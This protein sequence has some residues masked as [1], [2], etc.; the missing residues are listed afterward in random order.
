MVKNPP[1]SAGDTGDVGLIPGSG[2]SPGRG[3]GNPF[4]YLSL[5]N[6]RH[7]G[8]WQAIVHGVTKSQPCR[9]C[10]HSN[11]VIS[12][13]IKVI[14]EKR[15]NAEISETTFANLQIRKDLYLDRCPV[16]SRITFP[17]RLHIRLGVHCQPGQ[18][19][20]S[21]FPLF[22]RWFAQR[23][24]ILINAKGYDKKQLEGKSHT[25]KV[26]EMLISISFL[27]L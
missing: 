26:T 1:A 3:N 13:R 23:R 27:L 17:L 15:I 8:A 21:Q 5:G 24:T 9:A 19:S 12:T 25:F 20:L 10:T 2:R 16:L 6:S 14:T 7:S 18:L 11:T 22:N 4:Q